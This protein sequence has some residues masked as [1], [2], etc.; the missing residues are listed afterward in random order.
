MDDPS[1][2]C[3]PDAGDA[4]CSGICIMP[5]FCGGFAGIACASGYTCEDDPRDDCDPD[6]GGA[7]CSGLCV[8]DPSACVGNLC[9]S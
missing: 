1:D 6:D 3:D 9:E 7:D 4:D 2:A 8:P 5:V